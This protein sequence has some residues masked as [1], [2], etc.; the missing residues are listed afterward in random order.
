MAYVDLAVIPIPNKNKEAYQEQAEKMAK[1]FKE[2]G[3]ISVNECWGEEIPEGEV[4]SLPMAVQCS[5][6]ETVCFSRIV[7]PSKE[8]RNEA[9]PKVMEKCQPY[10]KPDLFDRKRMIYGSF[11]MIV[12]A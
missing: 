11:E 4:S 5:S 2:L 7:W 1:T 9:M 3:A 10:I 12:D 6:E 8:T